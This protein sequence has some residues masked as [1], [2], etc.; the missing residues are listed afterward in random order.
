MTTCPEYEYPSDLNTMIDTII[1]TPKDTVNINRYLCILKHKLSDVIT[2]LTECENPQTLKS[3]DVFDT[4]FINILVTYNELLDFIKIIIYNSSGIKQ[5]ISNIKDTSE[6]IFYIDFA[7]SFIYCCKRINKLWDSSNVQT[8]NKLMHMFL[9]KI[10][11]KTIMLFVGYYFYI[12][13]MYANR[14]DN[15]LKKINDEEDSNILF[16]IIYINSLLFN[17]QKGQ[18]IL[19]QN[20]LINTKNLTSDNKNKLNSILNYQIAKCKKQVSETNDILKKINKLFLII[21][22]LIHKYIEQP[23]IVY[24]I[25][26][27]FITI[28]QYEGNCWYISMITAMCYSDKSRAL[29]QS[30]FDGFISKPDDI[31]YNFIKYII[32]NITSQQ[33]KYNENLT[34]DC[35]YFLEFK[36]NQTNYLDAMYNQSIKNFL[37]ITELNSINYVYKLK[38]VYDSLVGDPIL[39][40]YEQYKEALQNIIL[41]RDPKLGGN[42][43]DISDDD[44]DDDTTAEE[45]KALKDLT[46]TGNKLALK[47]IEKKRIRENYTDLTKDEMEELIKIKNYG[48]TSDEYIII[49]HLYNIFGAKVLYLYK[50]DIP[51]I[52]CKSVLQKELKPEVIFIDYKGDKYLS[53]NKTSIKSNYKKIE[54]FSGTENNLTTYDT[55]NEII[56]LGDNIYKLDYILITNIKGNG[57]GNGN[58]KCKSKLECGHCISAITYDN[59]KYVYN[60]QYSIKDIKCEPDKDP[61]II[62]CSLIQQ[63]WN[64]NNPNFC[65]KPCY[66]KKNMSEHTTRETLCY[67][68]KDINNVNAYFKVCTK[69]QLKD[70]TKDLTDEDFTDFDKI[71]DAINKYEIYSNL[72]F[73]NSEK[74]YK[75]LDKLEEEYIF[76]ELDKFE[77]E[78]IFAEL[79]KLEKEEQEKI[80]AKLDELKLNDGSELKELNENELNE[81]Q[82]TELKELEELNEEATLIT[83]YENAARG[84][85]YITKTPEEILTERLNKIKYMHGIYIETEKKLLDKLKQIKKRPLPLQQSKSHRTISATTPPVLERKNKSSSMHNLNIQ[86]QE[87]LYLENRLKKLINQ[88]YTLSNIKDFIE[89]TLLKGG[90]IK[91]N[92]QKVKIIINKKIINRVVFKNRYVKINNNNVDLSNFKYSKKYDVYYIKKSDLNIL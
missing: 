73:D 82:S 37:S 15:L 19:L 57:N 22:Y 89:T 80:F 72:T 81:K 29:L 24:D 42:R 70:F 23:P 28:P 90:S 83:R 84:A 21:L 59:K 48:I 87:Q 36:N 14:Y 69:E 7:E 74:M 40:Y 63:D 16:V 44:E 51:E 13:D 49:S 6:Y 18:P 77:Q 50:T 75:E 76:A 30:Y 85:T 38:E 8:K 34:D 10:T 11:V 64:T 46:E 79:D 33:L 86:E 4:L 5:F 53:A 88:K 17:I 55:D 12:N 27:T 62:P 71:K 26:N 61:I 41:K 9:N 39:Y 31:F 60:S 52:Y 3:E 65:M 2:L 35:A 67:N 91:S 32:T 43:N 45:K 68:V 92:K 25:I 47:E 56:I 78:Q 20:N 58:G 54:I 66:Y 1:T